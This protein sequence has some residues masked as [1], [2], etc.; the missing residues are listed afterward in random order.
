MDKKQDIDKSKSTNDEQNVDQQKN[1]DI[2]Q[3]PN[4]TIASLKRIPPKRGA[5]ENPIKPSLT[6]FVLDTTTNPDVSSTV[7]P[8]HALPSSIF[9][10]TTKTAQIMP[11]PKPTIISHSPLVY[12]QTQ[13]VEAQRAKPIKSFLAVE[14]PTIKKDDICTQYNSFKLKKLSCYIDSL[15]FSLLHKYENNFIKDLQQ[16]IISSDISRES[17]KYRTVDRIIRF[18]HEIHDKTQPIKKIYSEDFRELLFECDRQRQYS[19]ISKNVYTTTQQDPHDFLSKI[20]HIINLP[21]CEYSDIKTYSKP[22]GNSQLI[23]N[24]IEFNT[25]TIISTYNSLLVYPLSE[26]SS[27]IDIGFSQID[28]NTFSFITPEENIAYELATGE[29]PDI[30][31]FIH[32]H[33]LID[34]DFKDKIREKDKH[35][36]EFFKPDLE[37]KKQIELYEKIYNS[38][39]MV[40]NEKLKQEVKQFIYRDDLPKLTYSRSVNSKVFKNPIN[41]FVISIAREN[42]DLETKNYFALINLPEKIQSY[43]KTLELVSAVVHYGVNLLQGHYVCY[44]KC[45]L[46]WYVMDNFSKDITQYAPFDITNHEIMT[47]CRLLVYM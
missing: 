1:I 12:K 8:K 35:L 22:R 38:H 32:K 39:I 25:E 41:Y 28:D 27:V 5:I 47:Q 14:K 29:Y 45:G 15:L 19:E 3:V 31:E 40:F 17:C 13:D 21:E 10:S 42:K 9:K 34:S 18:Y 16:I 43:G 7:E 30:V 2:R 33:N 23:S 44:F 26:R 46:H 24:F 37:H 11:S 4:V 20:L 36:L 6:R